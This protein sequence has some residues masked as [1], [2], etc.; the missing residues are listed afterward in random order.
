M[1]VKQYEESFAA[2][3]PIVVADFVLADSTASNTPNTLAPAM[4]A[5]DKLV[6]ATAYEVRRRIR[7]FIFDV[8]HRNQT[9]VRSKVSL[10]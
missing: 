1:G 7:W 2:I 3:L 4:L 9:I 10:Q 5:L 8:L 6:L